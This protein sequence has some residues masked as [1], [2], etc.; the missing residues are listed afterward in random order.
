[1][2][3]KALINYLPK[4]SVLETTDSYSRPRNHKTPRCRYTSLVFHVIHRRVRRHRNAGRLPLSRRTSSKM[5]NTHVTP[6]HPK[7]WTTGRWAH[8]R[9]ASLVQLILEFILFIVSIIFFWYLGVLFSIFGLI[10]AGNTMGAC[11]C[12]SNA[13]KPVAV[14]HIALGV[15]SLI[16]SLVDLVLLGLAKGLCDRNDYLVLGGEK[17]CDIFN[18][19]F[20][21]EI[22]CMIARIVTTITAARICCFRPQDWQ[23]TGDAYSAPAPTQSI[24]IVQQTPP[25]VMETANCI[26]SIPYV[27][28]YSAV[29]CMPENANTSYLNHKNH[30]SPRACCV[31]RSSYFSTF[32]L[33]KYQV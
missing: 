25:A 12:R 32:A 5:E 29:Q 22:L 33:L 21:I 2:K 18:G 20:A 24:I 8:A 26:V 3:H 16:G 1:M 30:S 11:C 4:L 13:G 9:W 14:T 19:L 28:Q 10:A 31:S 7:F 23:I 17:L 27:V 6:D 15:I